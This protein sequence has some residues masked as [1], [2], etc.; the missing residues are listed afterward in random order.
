MAI[1]ADYSKKVH[2][3][4][5]ISPAVNYIVS[6]LHFAA[7]V[8]VIA[9]A[10]LN[11]TGSLDNTMTGVAYLGGSAF[12]IGWQGFRVYKASEDTQGP[13]PWGR[14][15]L[16]ITVSVLPVLL[17]GFLGVGGVMP[18]STLGWFLFGSIMIQASL[19]CLGENSKPPST[20]PVLPPASSPSPAQGEIKSEKN[21]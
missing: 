16:R 6:F 8:T 21:D 14:E 4:D 11:L 18:S 9:V 1:Q 17:G 20:P 15:L 13:T 19:A 3:G 10:I 12:R 2:S 7:L 5:A